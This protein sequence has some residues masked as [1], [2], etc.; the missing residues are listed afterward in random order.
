MIKSRMKDYIS[1]DDIVNNGN[2][3]HLPVI[4]LEQ[5]VQRLEKSS[6]KHSAQ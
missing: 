5:A 3:L 6:P 4:G 1:I 2:I